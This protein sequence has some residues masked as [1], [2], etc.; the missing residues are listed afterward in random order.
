MHADKED[1]SSWL[2][3]V[4]HNIGATDIYRKMRQKSCIITEILQTFR[5]PFTFY[6]M[7][8]TFEGTDTPV[9]RELHTPCT[10]AGYV[11]LQ[12]VI[13]DKPCTSEYWDII[14]HINLV[15]MNRLFKI[16]KKDRLVLVECTWLVKHKLFVR[17]KNKPCDK[18]SALHMDNVISFRCKTW[19]T[20]AKEWLHRHRRFGWPTQETI[21]KLKSFGFFVVRKG[22]PLSLEIDLEW[23]ISLS[24]QERQLMFDLTDVQHKCYIVLK[25]FNREVICLDCITTYHWKTCLFYAIEENDG[26]IWN[27]KLLWNCIELCIRHMLKWVKCGFCPNYFIP[28]ENM[29]DG[30]LN[31]SGQVKL[32]KVLKKIL[33]LGFGSLLLVNENNLGDYFR[34]RTESVERFRLLQAESKRIYNETVY[35]ESVS[36]IQSALIAFN[37]KILQTE[38]CQAN[39]KTLM[40]IRSL[41]RTLKTLHHPCDDITIGRTARDIKYSLSFM[42][43]Y[44]YTCLASNISSIAF[45][46]SNTQIRDFL[47]LGCL[48]YLMNDD[49]SGRLKF[50]SVLYAAGSYS[51]CEW[52]IDIQDEEYITRNPSTCRCRHIKNDRELTE[53]NIINALPKHVSTCVSFLPTELPIIPDAMKYEMFRYV[54]I[55]LDENEK[56]DAF[57]RWQYRAIVDSNIYYFLLKYLI[58]RKL[59]RINEYE[60]AKAV[61]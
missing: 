54:G 56:T 61:S 32:E 58:K 52:W 37:H 13:E 12:L 20:M 28:E 57:G 45:Q 44:I 22:N 16:D 7:G 40:F 30:R 5:T 23:R 33:D 41:W 34:S 17:A 15:D 36:L 35:I 59:D 19:P 9:V 24:L 21:E 31:S 1:D 26:N 39:G 55:S 46:N 3:D 27:K 60:E 11:K 50:I 38:Y 14:G 25:T 51:D 18:S 2:Y 43:P 10:P 29:F 53:K 47:L 48:K 42:L 4:L 49:L 8:S 6:R